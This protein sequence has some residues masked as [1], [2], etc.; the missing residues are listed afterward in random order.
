MIYKHHYDSP[1]GGITIASNG[2]AVTG[3]GFDDRMSFDEAAPE[4]EPEGARDV[5]R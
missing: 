2:K 3:L 4:A 5:F 1:L